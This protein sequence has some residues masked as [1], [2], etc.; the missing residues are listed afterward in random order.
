V[1]LY[2]RSW[3]VRYE[4]EMLALLEDA[5]EKRRVGLDLARGAADAWLDCSA[6][7]AGPTALASG[8]L[9]TLAGVIVVGQPTPPDWPGYI[10]EIVPLTMA[11]VAVGLISIVALWSRHRDLAGRSGAL[12][13][14]L[15]LFGQV[16]WFVTLGAAVLGAA[17]SAHV[18]LG[19]TLGVLGSLAVALTIAK[20]AD[21][22][23][24]GAVTLGSSAMLFG[25]PIAWLGF[26]LAWTIAGTVL[27]RPV[28]PMW[29]GGSRPA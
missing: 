3:R 19:Q 13:V 2:P 16:A 20:S 22:R 1:R 23:A 10:V 29:P 8:A 24:S 15:A 27:L 12:G 11:A 21:L 18:A 26:G 25:S 7:L 9:W 6:G 5:G 4:E 28:D 14:A 17:S